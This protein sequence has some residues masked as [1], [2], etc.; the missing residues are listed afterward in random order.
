MTCDSSTDPNLCALPVV[1]PLQSAQRIQSIDVLR[2]L[3]VFGMLTVNIVSFGL[4]LSIWPDPNVL[5]TFD[6]TDQATLATIWI[7][8]EGSQRAIFAMLFGASVVLISERLEANDQIL[9]SPRAI[10][11]RRTL[12]LIVFGL[13]DAYLLLWFG[14]VLFLYG[15][16][17]LLLYR[18]RNT[19]PRKLAIASAVI[20]SIL[21]LVFLAIEFIPR[22]LDLSANAAMQKQQQG[23]ELTQL[24]KDTL[25][26]ATLTLPASEQEVAKE[27]EERRAGY[28][29]A[30]SSNA[31]TTIALNILLLP[32]HTL[33][34]SLGMMLLGMALFRWNVFDASRTIR[35]Y[36]TMTLLGFSVGLAVNTWEISEM[37]GND[38]QTLYVDWSNDIGRMAMAFGYIGA[39]MLICKLSLVRI[40]RE[41][42]AA[43][44]RMALTNYILQTIVCNVVFIGFGLFGALQL[45]QLY[46][47][48]ALIWLLQL[49]FSRL[50]LAKFS[51]GPLE[52]VWRS[53]TYKQRLAI[54]KQDRYESTV[55]D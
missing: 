33:W 9:P 13:V 26:L 8:F 27:I 50:W 2:G 37:I 30:F 39:V 32:V 41:S 36:T 34:D 12:Y 28:A 51:Y 14:D 22:M 20:F 49:F 3:A 35:F 48:V 16:A 1:Q 24:E 38:Y 55:T 40:L 11:Y 25:E 53:L 15:V 10:Y 31:K 42:L 43:V 21:A 23:I 6:Q 45:H 44:G 46:Y 17:G 19:T 18:F 29:S 4:P 7:A 52:W 5:Q 47:I 54:K